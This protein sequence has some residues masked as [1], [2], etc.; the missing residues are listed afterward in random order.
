MA[1]QQENSSQYQQ[2]WSTSSKY[3]PATFGTNLA[4]IWIERFAY[5]KDQTRRAEMRGSVDL[6][7]LFR[8]SKKTKG[9]PDISNLW[10]RKKT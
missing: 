7:L 10:S 2:T 8:R 9:A 6:E 1:S 3:S 5:N 4:A